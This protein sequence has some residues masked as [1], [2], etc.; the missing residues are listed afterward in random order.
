MKKTDHEHEGME[1]IRESLVYVH[2]TSLGRPIR[3]AVDESEGQ[4]ER[5]LGT[6]SAHEAAIK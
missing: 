5:E 6:A 1:R 2:V 3:R 4:G